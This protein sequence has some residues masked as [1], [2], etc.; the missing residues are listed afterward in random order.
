MSHGQFRKVYQPS[1]QLSVDESLILFKGCLHFKQY[2]KT[3]RSRFGIKLHELAT[4]YK[5]T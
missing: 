3:K 4:L 5:I 1:K 2:I